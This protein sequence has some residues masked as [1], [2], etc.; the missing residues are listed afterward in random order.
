MKINFYLNDKII[1]IEYL[2]GTLLIA[3]NRYKCLI[4]FQLLLYNTS[5]ITIHNITVFFSF[6]I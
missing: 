5:V 4:T 6:R 3:N 2:K 1:I